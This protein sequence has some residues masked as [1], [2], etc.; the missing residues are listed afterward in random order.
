M[1]LETFQSN[2]KKTKKMQS[3]IRKL[4]SKKTILLTKW[5]PLM[6]G[7]LWTQEKENKTCI[8]KSGNNVKDW[9]IG[10]AIIQEATL[11][12]IIWTWQQILK[13]ERRKNTLTDSGSK[14][15]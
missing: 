15:R 13:K 3:L 2:K 6:A 11:E 14:E 9:I 1:S 4:F 10:K 12:A 8:K 7:Q 5:K